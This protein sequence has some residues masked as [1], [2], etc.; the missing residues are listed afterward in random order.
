MD[1]RRGNHRQLYFR[2]FIRSAVF[3]VD[4]IFGGQYLRVS[5]Y[6]RPHVFVVC[7]FFEFLYLQPAAFLSAG[8]LPHRGR[9]EQ[10]TRQSLLVFTQI[11]LLYPFGTDRHKLSFP[12]YSLFGIYKYSRLC[13]G[14]CRQYFRLAHR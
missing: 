1:K 9:P 13:D 6:P 7:V 2:V 5:F 4:K 3:A 10:E 11:R 12:L 14:I 8:R